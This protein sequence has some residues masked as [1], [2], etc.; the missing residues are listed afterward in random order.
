MK[1]YVLVALFV[2]LFVPSINAQTTEVD[3]K[4]DSVVATQ[5]ATPDKNEIQNKTSDNEQNKILITPEA[6]AKQEIADNNY[7]LSFFTQKMDLNLEQLDKAKKFSEEDRMKR[8]SLLKSIYMLREQSR[9]L[10]QQSI[11]K[12]KSLLTPEQLAVFEE[13]RNEQLAY[14]QNYDIFSGNIQQQVEKERKIIEFDNKQ[15]EEESKKLEEQKELEEDLR[16][17]EAEDIKH[18]RWLD[19]N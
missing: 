17:R 18:G 12:F 6:K 4:S 8:E 5:N 13:L 1:L 19:F 7:S 14:R 16:R 15:M 3:V 2:V 9:E 10:E 11:E